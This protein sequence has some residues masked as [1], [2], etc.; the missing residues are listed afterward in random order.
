[1]ANHVHAAA[2]LLVTVYLSHSYGWTSKEAYNNG[3]LPQ[4]N[5]LTNDK[6]ALQYAVQPVGN[7][8]DQRPNPSQR[9][10]FSL[11]TCADAC[12]VTCQPMM[13]EEDKYFYVC[14]K[15][16]P[17]EKSLKDRIVGGAFTWPW[18]LFLGALA[19]SF[20]SCCGC[21]LW[22]CCCRSNH[23]ARDGVGMK[24]G[25]REPLATSDRRIEEIIPTA[26]QR[27]PLLLTPNGREES[28]KGRNGGSNIM[29]QHGV[30]HPVRVQASTGSKYVVDV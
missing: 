3:K 7:Q 18:V 14:Q 30:D 8:A 22:S 5:Q 15:L 16:R 6:V 24:G 28:E 25:S 29:Q 1:M 4:R 13:T 9:I 21:L 20:L 19:I 26:Q 2:I 17:P 27:R 12:M 23:E 11:K 10:Y